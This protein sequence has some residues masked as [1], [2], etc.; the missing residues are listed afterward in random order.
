MGQPL[1]SPQLHE[2]APAQSDDSREQLP[3][4]SVAGQVVLD[5][6]LEPIRVAR[7]AALESR[8][9]ARA[10]GLG[11]G[12]QVLYSD[13]DRRLA[14]HLPLLVVQEVMQREIRLVEVRGAANRGH[15]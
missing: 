7:V 2:A 4:E 3:E 1:A 15:P 6:P 13:M 10:L 12:L 11:Q 8:A 14:D 9:Q 5:Q